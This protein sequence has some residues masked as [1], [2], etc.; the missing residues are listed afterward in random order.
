MGNHFF[1]NSSSS[2]G[3]LSINIC[4]SLRHV[5]SRSLGQAPRMSLP[6][7]DSTV[8]IPKFLY[9]RVRRR[10]RAQLDRVARRGLHCK[11]KAPRTISALQ[12]AQ[13]PA[14]PARLSLDSGP[15]PGPASAS[16][17]DSDSE[18]PARSA[19]G[20][21]RPAGRRDSE[22][23]SVDGVCPT[24]GPVWRRQHVQDWPIVVGPQRDEV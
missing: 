6:N 9:F 24:P 11:A 5:S 23:E 10:H 18:S 4:L 7:I 14:S 2:S 12:Q 8:S 1:T 20:P 17:G 13:L 3:M 21:R 19:S 16:D 22:A 15:E